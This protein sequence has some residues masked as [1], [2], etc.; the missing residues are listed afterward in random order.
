MVRDQIEGLAQT[1]QH[2]E[3]K[4]VDLEDAERVDVVLVPFDDRPVVHRGILDGN[5][6]VQP[7]GGDD[8]AADML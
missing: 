5:Q 8:E 6:L 3:R 1:G 7:P 2:A 4:D